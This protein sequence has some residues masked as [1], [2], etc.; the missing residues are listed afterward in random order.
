MINMTAKEFDRR[1]DNG[2]DID[3][4]MEADEILTMADLKNIVKEKKSMD[5][6]KKA[7]EQISLSFPKEFIEIIDN[8]IKEIG[9][10]R[11]AFIK[12][13]LAQQLGIFARR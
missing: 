12:M 3:T 1:F 5:F 10:N 8:K 2:E 6:S 11:E 13:I 9:V 4:L 7:H